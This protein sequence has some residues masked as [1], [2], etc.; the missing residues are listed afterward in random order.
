MVK[1]PCRP[2]QATGEQLSGCVVSPDRQTCLNMGAGSRN[3]SLGEKNGGHEVVEGRVVR[4]LAKSLL[5]KQPCLLVATGVEVR[6]D[7][8]HL[9]LELR[10]AHP[11][12]PSHSRT[13]T[14]PAE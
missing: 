9:I 8:S 3:L 4:R 12:L 6:H 13:R 7:A 1:I 2:R 11:D 5:A 14:I 10:N